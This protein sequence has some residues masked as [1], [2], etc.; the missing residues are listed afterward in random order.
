MK[1]LGWQQW[2]LVGLFLVALFAT[3][4]FGFRAIRRAVYWSNHKDEQIKPWMSVRYVAHSYR[5]PPPVLFHAL[6][7]EPTPRDKRPLR[8][9]ARE[10]N[11]P[12]EAL[13][14]ELYSAINQ[15]RQPRPPPQ[16]PPATD[17]GTPP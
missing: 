11:R 15:A 6:G 1:K 9:V 16:P 12:V 2:L 8:V 14:S 5:V 4:L 17:G 10:Q 7:L 3:G 13:I